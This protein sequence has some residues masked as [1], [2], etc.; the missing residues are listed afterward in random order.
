MAFFRLIIILV[1][2]LAHPIANHQEKSLWSSSRK[3][4]TEFKSFGSLENGLPETN[5]TEEKLSWLRSQVIGA[6]VAFETPFGE[7]LLTYADH[8]ATGR[9]LR[10]IEDY[11]LHNVLPFYG[12]FSDLVVCMPPY[13]SFLY[14]FLS[15]FK[16]YINI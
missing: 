8:T 1:I 7:R 15:R 4:V 5:S 3:L 9:S 12:N 16:V 2:A 13:P 6:N 10:H 11:I 14:C